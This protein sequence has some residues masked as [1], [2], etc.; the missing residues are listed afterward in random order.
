[1]WG[2]SND[3]AVIVNPN[4]VGVAICAPTPTKSRFPKHSDNHHTVHKLQWSYTCGYHFVLKTVHS[5][6]IK[7]KRHL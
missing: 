5:L 2:T 6:Q 7:I 1:M 3:D 4:D